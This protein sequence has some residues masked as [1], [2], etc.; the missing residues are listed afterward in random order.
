M[1]LWGR[2]TEMA[3]KANDAIVE[4]IA[5]LLDS[6]EEY[7]SDGEERSF[8]D[9][10]SDYL[11]D[12]AEAVENELE[13]RQKEKK[14]LSVMTKF[15]EAISSLDTDLTKVRS[16]KVK[17]ENIHN[18]ETVQPQTPPLVVVK[19]VD[20]SKSTS[21]ND[22]HN[23]NKKKKNN[24]T[25]ISGDN[26]KNV[27]IKEE[28]K[29]YYGKNISIKETENNI[30]NNDT[31]PLLP[32]PSKE[33]SIPESVN[34]SKLS[35]NNNY[36]KEDQVISTKTE[37]INA[38]KF[39]NNEKSTK[40]NMEY[41][42]S[43][44]VNNNNNNNNYNNKQNNIVHQESNPPSSISK[45]PAVVNEK[46]D[47]HQPKQPTS[48]KETVVQKKIIHQPPPLQQNVS[49]TPNSPPLTKQKLKHAEET[50]KTAIIAQERM[51][52][53]CAD[54]E[55]LVDTLG[56][57]V[58]R[59]N[60]KVL[61]KMETEKALNQQLSRSNQRIDEL[62]VEIE[63]LQNTLIEKERDTV[64]AKGRA[65]NYG[66]ELRRARQELDNTKQINNENFTSTNDEILT[67]Q[68]RVSSLE[69]TEQKY[70]T[71]EADLSSCKADL[72]MKTEDLIRAN[73]E[74]DNLRGVLEGFSEELSET[75]LKCA[76]EISR[77][78]DITKNEIE[79]STKQYRNAEKLWKDKLNSV[80]EQNRI[81]TERLKEKEATLTKTFVEHAKL[82]RALDR[83]AENLSLSQD[84]ELVDRR[85]VNKLLTTYL[86]RSQQFNSEILT[87]MSNI[88]GFTEEQKIKIGQARKRRGTNTTNVTSWLV[89]GN[90]NNA[91]NNKKKIAI[92][93]DPNKTNLSELWK[94]YLVDSDDD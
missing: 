13:L 34:S 15:E 94:S 2:L 8:S 44:S 20:E 64:E 11:L 22:A 37:T 88:L 36:N 26:T 69:I 50:A 28:E 89:N 72:N 40:K 29:D 25:R 51:A 32:A 52:N 74:L 42:S 92:K 80:S 17:K 66:K 60:A 59:L 82:K 46:I 53:R 6:E 35:S 73:E 16:N 38:K 45:R 30:E 23:N 4:N 43:P 1:S 75:K 87:L 63:N 12:E 70:H 90:D 61:K 49:T 81:L 93:V 65:E 27:I 71:I 76:N 19:D 41:I 68:E 48:V 31:I 10:D 57:Q 62:K 56:S 67:L 86:D 55:A 33:I 84:E 79:T 7:Y 77:I 21:N 47:T 78:Q 83:A 85:L 5:P 91:N 3:E 24:D 9:E 54:A 18:N 58:Q 39:S 14:L